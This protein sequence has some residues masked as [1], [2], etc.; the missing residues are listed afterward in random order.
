MSADTYHR[1]TV[2]ERSVRLRREHPK[3]VLQVQTPIPNERPRHEEHD[4]DHGN[5]AGDEQGEQIVHHGTRQPPH[6]VKSPDGNAEGKP[7]EQ[8]RCNQ[9]TCQTH[10]GHF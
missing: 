6:G 5:E 9:S 10:D 1:Q 4:Q 8:T 7:A 2:E 3:N